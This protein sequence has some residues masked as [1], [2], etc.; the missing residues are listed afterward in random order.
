MK[1]GG[2]EMACMCQQCGCQYKVDLLIPDELWE[3]IKPA[4]KP[5]G[6][7]LLCGACI[8]KNIEK[9]SDYSAWKMDQI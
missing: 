8:M 2:D 4:G 1:K 6:A 5:E 3:K 7:G 9:I